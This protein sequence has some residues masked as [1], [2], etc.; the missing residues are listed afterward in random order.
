MRLKANPMIAFCLRITPKAKMG[1]FGFILST[2][3]SHVFP[4]QTQR[5]M[6]FFVASNI[7]CHKKFYFGRCINAR[8][9]GPTPPFI[10]LTYFKI[11]F[12]RRQTH[13]QHDKVCNK[14]DLSAKWKSSVFNLTQICS[15]S[16]W[17]RDILW[18]LAAGELTRTRHR[19][20]Q[21]TARS[22]FNTSAACSWPFSQ[23][24]VEQASTP[25]T[26]PT[27][28]YTGIMYLYTSRS[29]EPNLS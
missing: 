12:R 21:Y 22:F 7:R 15:P 18:F 1:K 11:Y 2:I 23:S 16:T 13:F 25:K 19:D 9:V 29:T 26:P 10:K 8:F 20:T 14:R 17:E 3:F 5:R 24:C 27:E 28:R 4:I 6:D